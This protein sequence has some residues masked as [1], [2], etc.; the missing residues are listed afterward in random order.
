MRAFS[1]MS[2]FVGLFALIVACTS[3]PV[4]SVTQNKPD[5]PEPTLLV[6]PSLL[7]FD[8]P[9]MTLELLIMNTGEGTLRWTIDRCED[10][11]ECNLDSGET[12]FGQPA[13]VEVFIN[14]KE[15]PLDETSCSGEVMVDSNGG[16]LSIPVELVIPPELMTVQ[17]FARDQWGFVGIEGVEVTIFQDQEPMFTVFT[18]EDGFYIVT[19]VPRTCNGIQAEYAG[20]STGICLMPK[21]VDP[22]DPDDQPVATKDFLFLLLEQ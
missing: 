18:G 6:L 5:H 10:W 2:T 22:I 12:T 11:I 20:E 14:S 1:A 3:A 8:N 15:L 19:D 21:C 13:V 17:G 16:T 4:D 7:D 9:N